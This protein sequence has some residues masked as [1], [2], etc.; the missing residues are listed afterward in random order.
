MDQE[1][2]EFAPVLKLTTPAKSLVAWYEES[3]AATT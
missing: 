3:L 2:V 1:F